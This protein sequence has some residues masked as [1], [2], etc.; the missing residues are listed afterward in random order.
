MN[1][2]TSA[3]SCACIGV[4]EEDMYADNLIA[5]PN[6]SMVRR[7]GGRGCVEV[8]GVLSSRQSARKMGHARSGSEAPSDARRESERL[9]CRDV[10]PGRVC[11]CARVRFESVELFERTMEERNVVR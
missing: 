9:D 6:P 10:L 2:L 3:R 11:V 1:Q 5:W 7:M 8:D 4:K